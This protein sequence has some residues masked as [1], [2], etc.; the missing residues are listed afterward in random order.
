MGVYSKCPS[1]HMS[2]CMCMCMCMLYVVHV[3][4]VELE[5]FWVENSGE[6]EPQLLTELWF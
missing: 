1:L 5:G 3:Q 4:H 6:L 2:M